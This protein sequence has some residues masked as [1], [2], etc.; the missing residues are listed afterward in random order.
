[1]I[2]LPPV[3][4]GGSFEEILNVRIPQ[5]KSKITIYGFVIFVGGGRGT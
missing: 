3:I 1:M 5:I 2:P 4:F